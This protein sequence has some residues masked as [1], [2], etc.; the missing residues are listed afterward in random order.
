EINPNVQYNLPIKGYNF[1][2]RRE[3]FGSIEYINTRLAPE[4]KRVKVF[5]WS[6][7]TNP[8]ERAIRMTYEAGVYNVNGGYTWINREEPFWM[9]ISPMGVNKG[10]YF[11]IYAPILNENIYTRL[12]IDYYGFRRIIDTFE[13]TEKPY[14]LKPLNIYYH[15][16]SG[17]KIASLEALRR[18][19]EWALAQK[20]NPI[21]LSE[22]AQKVLEYRNF[23]LLEDVRDGSLLMRGGGTL[24][25]L[26]VDSL[27][28]VDIDSSIGVVGYKQHDTSTYISLDSSGEYKI[29]FSQEYP[30][31]NLVEVNGKV[32]DFQ[33]TKEG[34]VIQLQAHV[35]LEFTI[36]TK[37][38][39]RFEPKADSLNVRSNII[40]K[41][42]RIK[43]ARIKAYCKK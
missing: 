12:W 26:R 38:Q 5:L 20:P 43:N 25:T 2:L 18:V 24:R 1:D 42:K 8:S 41:Y 14:R 32:S 4:G 19:Y 9:Y 31:F 7:D 6:G 27:T 30:R 13:F 40:V 10:E 21:Y 33:K 22:Y 35:P 39:L 29:V 23:A 37:C 28:H 36:Q 34:Y 3:I 15:M 11:Q 17:Q 16:Y